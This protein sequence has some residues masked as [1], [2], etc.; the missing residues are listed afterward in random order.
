LGSNGGGGQQTQAEAFVAGG[1]NPSNLST[2][3]EYNKPQ[4]FYNLHCKTRC[5]DAT[6]TQ[7]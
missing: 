5:L 7:I 3:Q 4:T 6:C 2:T 1:Y